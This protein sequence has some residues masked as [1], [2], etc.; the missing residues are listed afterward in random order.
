MDAERRRPEYQNRP[1]RITAGAWDR[2]YITAFELAR[3]AAW[4]NAKSVAVIT[5]NNPGD[6]EGAHKR[7]CQSSDRGGEGAQLS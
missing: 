6:I 5:V 3:I 1:C 4:K 2:G 7:R